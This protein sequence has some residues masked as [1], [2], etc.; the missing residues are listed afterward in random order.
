MNRPTTCGYCGSTIRQ[1]A[2]GRPRIYCDDTCKG[3]A[4][5]ARDAGVSVAP[6]LPA[7][8]EMARTEAAPS[9]ASCMACSDAREGLCDS[10]GRIIGVA[11]RE[12]A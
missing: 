9:D 6:A 2:T 1:P 12:T 3:A 7:R 4:R 5:K 10:C 8:P 11:F